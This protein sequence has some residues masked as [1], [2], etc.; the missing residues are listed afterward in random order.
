MREIGLPFSGPMV[1]AILEDKKS[2]TRRIK[3]GGEVGDHIWVKETYGLIDLLTG[4]SIIKGPIPKAKEI[5]NFQV[6]Y[7]STMSDFEQ[8]FNYKWYS[9]IFMPRW[10][11]RITLE[12]IAVRVERLQEI[13][14]EDAIAEGVD[15][16]EIAPG[17]YS[18]HRYAFYELWDSLNGKKYPWESNP[19]VKVI[20]F[21]R[22]K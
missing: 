18:D 6:I 11:S 4:N 17:E 12:V 1:R 14:E 21:R 13:T 15:L 19:W 16:D 22:L 2:M 8:S 3:F 7:Q 5:K 10:A 20:T 9:S